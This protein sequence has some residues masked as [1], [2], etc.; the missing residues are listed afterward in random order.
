MKF[1]QIKHFAIAQIIKNVP[2]RE[3]AVELGM[4]TKVL[5]NML[6]RNGIKPTMVRHENG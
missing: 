6:Y 2:V 5:A 4:E 3:I 1:A